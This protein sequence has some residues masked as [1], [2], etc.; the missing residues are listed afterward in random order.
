[1]RGRGGLWGGLWALPLWAA[2]EPGPRRQLQEPLDERRQRRRRRRQQQLFASPTAPHPPAPPCPNPPSP[3][4]LLSYLRDAIN[5][6]GTG[7]GVFFAYNSDLTLSAQRLADALAEPDTAGKAPCRRADRTFF[8]NRTLAK[9]IMGARA[10]GAAQW[11]RGRRSHMSHAPLSL[12]P[13]STRHLTLRLHPL[14]ALQPFP[15]PPPPRRRCRRVRAAHDPRQRGPDQRRRGDGA[16]PVRSKGRA[17]L[18][19][20]RPA[21]GRQQSLMKV[22]ARL[23]HNNL[24]HPTPTHPPAPWSSTSRSSPAAASTARA[25][26]TG[27][28]APTARRA[29]RA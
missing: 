10:G 6:E 19:G 3:A 25:R 4:R 22:T 20:A 23:A 28:A 18:R 2:A 24:P 7:R 9:P 26:A 14:H 13:M 15:T 27:A 16:R 11:A 17:G 1:V 5:P 29:S 12:R 21:I 8:W